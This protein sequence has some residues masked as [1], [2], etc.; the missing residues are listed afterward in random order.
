VG[1]DDDEGTDGVGDEVVVVVLEV[2][3]VVVLEMGVVD[4]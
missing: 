3:V 2:V 1:G 4:W